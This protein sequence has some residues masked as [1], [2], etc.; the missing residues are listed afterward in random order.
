V[1]WAGATLVLLLLGGAVWYFTRSAPEPTPSSPISR[2]V[3][4][5][6]TEPP[7]NV[8]QPITVTEVPK[9]INED[10]TVEM[11]V[12]SVGGTRDKLKSVF[13]NSEKSF[14][15]EGNVSVM[16]TAEGL[17]AYEKQESLARDLDAYKARFEGKK[18]RVKG[19]IHLWQG[20]PEIKVI[21]PSQVRIIDK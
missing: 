7:K 15:K 21:D 16:I 12:C 17:E 1:L 8:E 3:D 2:G 9:H 18:I 11:L 4:R 20:N 14:K 10:K 5:G 19:T 6:T 13:L